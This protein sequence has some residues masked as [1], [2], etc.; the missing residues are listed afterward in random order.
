MVFI[1][2]NSLGNFVFASEKEF[3]IKENIGLIVT[4]MGVRP[5]EAY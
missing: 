4:C 5:G 2:L 1:E 3:I